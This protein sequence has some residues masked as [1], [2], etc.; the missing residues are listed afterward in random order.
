MSLTFDCMDWDAKTKKIVKYEG[1]AKMPV[2][3]G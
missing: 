2:V 3:S 1:V